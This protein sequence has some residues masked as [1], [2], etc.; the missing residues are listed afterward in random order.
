MVF[1]QN[2]ENCFRS[3]WQKNISEIMT[4]YKTPNLVFCCFKLVFLNLFLTKPNI[5]KCKL[6]KI[7]NDFCKYDETKPFFRILNGLHEF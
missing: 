7:M 2:V 6:I 5:I 3:K 4:W 1:G